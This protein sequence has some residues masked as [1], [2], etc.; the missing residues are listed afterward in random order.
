M[1]TDAS[2][3]IYVFDVTIDEPA[4]QFAAVDEMIAPASRMRNDE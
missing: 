4:T 2:D 1:D 3:T